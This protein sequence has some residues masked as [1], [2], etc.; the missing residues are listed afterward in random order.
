MRQKNHN[1]RSKQELSKRSKPCKH[2][3][4]CLALGQGRLQNRSLRCHERTSSK[5]D[6]RLERWSKKLC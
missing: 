5:S 6:I 4:S 2:Y 3:I 1:P